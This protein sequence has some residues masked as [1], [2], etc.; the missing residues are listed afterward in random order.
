MAVLIEVGFIGTRGYARSNDIDLPLWFTLLTLATAAA[1]IAVGVREGRTRR[2][3][4]EPARLDPVHAGDRDGLV[5]VVLDEVEP[6]GEPGVPA[7]FDAEV[8]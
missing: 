6:F 7:R 4:G 8:V 1:L 2:R 5:A 3:E